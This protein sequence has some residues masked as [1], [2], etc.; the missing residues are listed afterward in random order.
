[1]ADGVSVAI[2]GPEEVSVGETATFTADVTGAETWVWS[3]PDGRFLLDRSTVTMTPTSAGRAELVLRSR[4]ADGT[5]LETH[6]RFR[7]EER[8]LLRIRC[9]RITFRDDS[10]GTAEPDE[11]EHHA[12]HH[13]TPRPSQLR[14]RRRRRPRPHRLR[15]RRDR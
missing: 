10:W 8:E 6:H 11:G 1:A 9:N 15:L 3:L 5:V 4:T 7:V 14:P 13:C 2:D 12:H